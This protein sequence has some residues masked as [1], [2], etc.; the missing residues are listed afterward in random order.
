MSIYLFNPQKGF[1]GRV[2]TFFAAILFSVNLIQAAKALD[3]VEVPLAAEVT[4]KIDIV[5]REEFKP[6][7]KTPLKWISGENSLEVSGRI[8]AEMFYGNNLTLLNNDNCDL[9]KIVVPIKHTFDLGA[10]YGFGCPSRGHDI[11]KLKMTLRTKGTWGAP[12][13]IATTEE[14]TVKISDLV[15]GPHSHVI[16]RNIFWLREMWLE[17]TLNEMFGYREGKWRHSIALGYFPFLLGRGIALGDAYATDPDLLGYYSPSAIDQ[18]APGIKLTGENV[19]TS[20]LSYDIYLGILNNKSNTFNNVNQ[21]IRGQQYGRLTRPQ[22]GFG[23][24]NMLFALRAKWWPIKA[25]WGEMVIEPYILYDR[26]K[27]QKVAFLGDSNSKLWTAGFAF[28]GS[29]GNVEFGYDFAHNFGRQR[30]FG[31]DSNILNA[32]IRN[33]AVVVVNSDVLA[34]ASINGEL[35]GKPALFTPANQAIIDASER[36]EVQNN[37]V[38]GA[39]LKNSSDR[40]NNPYTNHY[41]GWMMV[42]DVGYN[43]FKGLKMCVGGGIATGD[44]N[45]NRS[46]DEIDG[47]LQEVDYKGFISLQ[48]LYSGTRL[49]SAF[50]FS[51]AGRIPRLL[52]FPS[53]ELGAEF[54]QS[55][56]RFTNIVFVGWSLWYEG[57]RGNI[58]TNVLSY[59]QEHATRIFVTASESASGIPLQSATCARKWLGV[60]T[61][62]FTDYKLYD[63]IKCYFI[64]SVFIP[65]TH[66]KDIS[67]LPLSKAQQKFLDRPDDTGNNANFVPTVGHDVAY[68]LNMGVEYKF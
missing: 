37:Q 46:I 41:K 63:D 42:G 38:I 32:E 54:P 49:R 56:N 11:V 62:L 27:E 23:V 52:S 19:C 35:A 18:Y 14:A 26:A 25:D 61:N 65:G 31:W 2:M 34:V 39:N 8:R 33:G 43:F 4:E 58:N 59:W 20:R 47:L 66:F 57:S 50:L 55:V 15:T 10:L 48:E 30:V 60:E 5:A 21:N 68:T 51:G 64:G 3:V 24:I 13:T 6:L 1:L 7:K 45:P 44:E 12:E 29:I 17:A 16:S 22:R 9:D 36:S 28:E 40:F 53:P 67:G